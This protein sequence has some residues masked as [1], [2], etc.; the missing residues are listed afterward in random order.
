MC[1]RDRD[2]GLEA[3]AV[4]LVVN[5]SEVPALPAAAATKDL[6]NADPVWRGE[7]K[8][9]LGALSEKYENLEEVRM[10][11][12]VTDNLPESLGG[13]NVGRSDWLVVKIDRNADSLA[14]Q[15]IR[16][17]QSDVRETINEAIRETT[18]AKD[19]MEWHKEDVKKE[20]LPEQAEKHLAEARD[21]L[22][23]A[24]EQLEDLAERM[25]NGVQAARA[26]DVREAAEEVAESRER[27]EET[28]LQDTPEAREEELAE[29]RQA[30]EE[31]LSLIHI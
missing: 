20:E 18:E 10:S 15:E 16:A 23:N 7:E 4:D 5:G 6:L 11:V 21:K 1:I 28:P 22:A 12:L 26:E 19:R 3:V 14:R 2:Y 30:A 13:P 25:E 27:L 9:S 31:A 29:A 24:Q 17:Q 8:V